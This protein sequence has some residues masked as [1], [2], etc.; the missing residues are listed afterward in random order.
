MKNKF[1]LEDDPED[2]LNYFVPDYN[3]WPQINRTY[4]VYKDNK[5]L[6]FLLW[7]KRFYRT[8]YFVVEFNSFEKECF[9]LCYESKNNFKIIIPKINNFLFVNFK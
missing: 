4:V 3:I 9:K 2:I 8:Y 6:N 1:F 5:L 7:Y